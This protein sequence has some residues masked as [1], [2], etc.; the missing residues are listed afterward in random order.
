MKLQGKYL[1]ELLNFTIQGANKWK[2]EKRPIITL[3]EKY[4]TD[5]D[6]EEFLGTG[7]ISRLET[8]ELS[9]SKIN[10]YEEIVL[11]NALYAVKD[12]L[13]V[14]T[15]KVL[16]GGGY[17]LKDVLL[18]ALDDISNG[19]E[20]PNID[21]AKQTL[22]ATV[23][24]VEITVLGIPTPKKVESVSSWIEYNLSKVEAYVLIKHYQQIF[25]MIEKE[26]KV[27]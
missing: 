23:N 10:Q 6:L 13:K 22:I 7:K 17:K 20:T 12:K 3:L 1:A 24:T 8:A 21:L 4:Y 25:D 18:R 19:L 27:K 9:K 16:Q 15:A 14:Y 5:E 11:D 26:D 2:R